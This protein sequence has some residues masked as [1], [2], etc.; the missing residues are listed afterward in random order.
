MNAARLTILFKCRYVLFCT[1]ITSPLQALKILEY[2]NFTRTYCTDPNPPG[3]LNFPKGSNETALKALVC[4][5]SKSVQTDLDLN[6]TEIREDR[7]KNI[8][9]FNWTDFNAM[10]IEIYRY[11]DTLVHQH[12]SQSDLAKLKQLKEDFRLSWSIDIGAKEVFEM[13]YAIDDNDIPL[14]ALNY[15]NIYPG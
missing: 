4:R 2:D 5:L 8:G 6:I 7:Y 15:S 1:N 12:D 9:S 13:R 11:I 10:T 14:F 3:L